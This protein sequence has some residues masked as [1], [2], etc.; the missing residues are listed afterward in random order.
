[1]FIALCAF[2]LLLFQAPWS[3]IPGNVSVATA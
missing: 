2:L 3:D 1:M